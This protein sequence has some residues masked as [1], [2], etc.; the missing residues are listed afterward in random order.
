[1][2]FGFSSKSV[3]SAPP[4]EMLSSLNSR[5]YLSLPGVGR[6]FCAS[7][8]CRVRVSPLLTSVRVSPRLAAYQGCLWISTMAGCAFLLPF[9]TDR[10]FRKQYLSG[11][12]SPRNC[13]FEKFSVLASAG[14][15]RMGSSTVTDP[16]SCYTSQALG[17]FLYFLT[18]ALGWIY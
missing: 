1:M 5:S 9:A 2:I 7:V 11:A 13:A 16:I 18:W 8:H 3:W 14:L 17:A 15:L 12:Q 10:E 6:I 4:G